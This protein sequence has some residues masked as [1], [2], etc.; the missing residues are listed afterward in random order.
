MFEYREVLV[1]MRAG[2]SNHEIDRAGLMGR[3]AAGRARTVFTGLG[4][5]DAVAMPSDAQIAAA[6]ARGPVIGAVTPSLCEP[7][8]DQVTALATQEMDATTIWAKLQRE[9]GFEGSYSSVQRFVASLDLRAPR[10]TA[11]LVFAPGEAA[12]LDFGKGPELVDVFT[13]EVVKTWFFAMTLCWSR[14]MYIEFVTDQKV[15][16]WLGCHNRAFGFLG[17][18]PRRVII[19]NAKCAITK[20]CY[21]DPVVQRAYYAHAEGWGIQIDALPPAQP[22]MKGRVER[23]VAF[24]KRGFVAGREFRDLT[25]LNAQARAWTMQVGNRIHG[26]TC[27][28]PLT[29]FAEVERVLLAPLPDVW[30]EPVDVAV[31]KVHGDCH[32]Q[33]EKRYY[34]APYRLAH[35]QVFVEA[36]E[37]SVRLYRDHHLIASHPRLERPGERSTI[38][39]HLPPDQ[40]AW[41]LRDQ[42]WCLKR[43]AQIGICT[44]AAVERL[45]DDRVVRN[46]RAAQGILKLADS[47]GAGRLEAACERALRFDNVSRRTIKAILDN[48][49]D[50]QPLN[51]AVAPAPGGAYDGSGT[52]CRDMSRLFD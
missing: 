40:L 47:Y 5:L 36:S 4:W 41:R 49:W 9:H 2:A 28:R 11:P 42:Q 25:D 6:F 30:P 8:R 3:K 33:F 29:R 18:A 45:F 13:G 39:E 48:G 46:L 22:Q 51:V 24:V 32:V 44:R 10:A 35:Q 27:E 26:T 21:H 31:A 1:R 37:T 43:S 7:F 23:T 20:A 14:H 15:K 12:Q 52:Y 50:Q 16:T 17:G 34:S 38:D 19:D